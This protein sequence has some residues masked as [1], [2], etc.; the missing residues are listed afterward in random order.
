MTTDERRLEIARQLIRVR[1]SMKDMEQCVVFASEVD[2]NSNAIYKQAFI[3][4]AIVS[5]ARPFSRNKNHQKA[6]AHTPVSL[7]SLTLKELELHKRI[8]ELRDKAIAHSDFDKNPTSVHQ[9]EKAGGG[10]GYIFRA[11]LYDPLSEA[12][13]IHLILKLGKKIQ[14]ILVDKLFELQRWAPSSSPSPND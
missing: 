13:N 4:A 5:Y 8:C 9:F 1:I 6:T 12:P 11:Q 14:S 2:S 10:Q 7:K 3:T